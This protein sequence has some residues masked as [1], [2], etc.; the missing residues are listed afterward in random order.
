MIKISKQKTLSI[1]ILLT[2]LLV[3]TASAALI[4]KAQAA[5]P[6]I[7]QKGL[8]VLNNVV[9]IDLTK[10]NVT[11]R[12]YPE[13]VKASYM[14]VVPQRS[15]EY[16]LTSGESK[17]KMFYTFANG[18]LQMI[19][20]LEN[21]GT[22]KS[23]KP[24]AIANI[25]AARSFLSK[26]QISN[27][28]PLYGE[29]Q[30]TLNGLDPRI[31]QTKTSG[32]MHLE[33]ATIDGY[34]NFKWYYTSNGAIAPYSKFITLSFEDGFLSAFVNNWQLYGIGST[35]VNLIKEEALN[36][37]LE[38]AKVHSWG[39]ALDADTLDVKNFN[40]SNVCWTALI[41]DGSLNVNTTR[42]EDPLMLYP[43]W[44]VG[45]A[46]DK[47]Y[48][49]MYGIEVDVWADTGEVRS[50]EEAW[51]TMTPS[52]YALVADDRINRFET[53]ASVCLCSFRCPSWV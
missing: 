36:I 10:Y 49:N 43:V 13:D 45:I 53:N 25:Q 30:S 3:S 9:G 42:S 12:E 17:L 6:T 35:S 22:P 14:G 40:E 26:Y 29:L 27:G 41:F 33:T 46:L 1:T 44:R 32:N 8:T 7:Q 28:D 51:G 20:V 11:T 21:E 16:T 2:L 50:V 15:V 38:T 18:N 39:V 47:W 34:T 19:Q 5:E 31:N 24:P 48:G 4:P 52:D 23:T 37:A